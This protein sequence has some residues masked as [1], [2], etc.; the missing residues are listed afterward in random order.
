[1]ISFIDYILQDWQANQNTSLKSRCVLIFFRSAQLLSRWPFP[2][3]LWRFVYQLVVEGFLGT[4]LPW[5]TQIGSSLQLQHGIALVVNHGTKIGSN[6]VLRHSTS[7]GNKFLADGST[8]DCPIIGDN[9]EVG[10]NVVI[11]GPISIGNR[12]IIGAGAVV[13]KDVPENAIVAGNPAKFLRWRNDKSI[14]SD[15]TLPSFASSEK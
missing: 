10:S 14:L 13:V 11:M 5:D 12:A 3:F 6:C 2:L 9:V 8:T 7:I 4:E 1:M 15:Q